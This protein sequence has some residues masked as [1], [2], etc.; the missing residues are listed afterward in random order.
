MTPIALIAALVLSALLTPH[1]TDAQWGKVPTITLSA[2]A[3]DA[4]IPLTLEAVAFWNRQLAEVG[5]PFRWGEVTQTTYTLP[6][7]YLTRLSAAVLAREPPP[8]V[9]ELMNRMPGDII[10]ALSD[11][12]FISFASRLPSGRSGIK[13]N[14]YKFCAAEPVYQH[15]AIGGRS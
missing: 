4:R 3:Q 9:P 14:M 1:P 12:D 15:H 10:L 6:A 5:T 11:G 8:D 7:D 13:L 2:P